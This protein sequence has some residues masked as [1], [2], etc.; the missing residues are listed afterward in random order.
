MVLGKKQLKKQMKETMELLMNAK[1]EM[2][3]IK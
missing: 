3:A 2:E 1:S